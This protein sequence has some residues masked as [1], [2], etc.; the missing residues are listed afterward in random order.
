MRL[1]TKLGIVIAIAVIGGVAYSAADCGNRYQLCKSWC[2]L[3]HFDNEAAEAGCRT[4][5]ALEHSSCAAEDGLEKATGF[6]RGLS[7]E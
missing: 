6:L 4:R 1:K 2:G 3:R 5:C 7:G